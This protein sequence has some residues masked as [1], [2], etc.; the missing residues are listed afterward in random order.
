MGID[1]KG[2]VYY[3]IPIASEEDLTGQQFGL[4]TVLKR[5][6][7]EK[8]HKKHWLCLCACGNVNCVTTGNLIH[9][10]TNSCGCN[11]GK[12][13]AE[14][15]R[16][17][18]V[19]MKFGR[20]T[21]VSAVYIDGFGTMWNCDCDCGGH[22][23]VSGANLRSGITESCGCLHR[24]MM[25]SKW[26]K[27]L[28]GQKFGKL[29]ALYPSNKTSGERKRRM[30]HCICDCGNET[31]VVTDCL[32]SGSILSCGCV[33][34]S[35]GEQQIDKML[36]ENNIDFL[37]Q[38]TFSDLFG[39]DGGLLRYDFAILNSENCIE[40]LIEFDGPQHDKPADFF[41]GQ[42]AY[43]KLV[44]HDKRKNE[45]AFIHNIPLVRIPYSQRDKITL[46]MLLGNQ[47]TIQN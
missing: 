29:T 7:V 40:R 4:L 6:M 5:V 28:T 30:W 36:R 44:E 12:A 46:D 17:D 2:R 19:G 26:S 15:Q 39:V 35:Y 10:K 11:A 27:D 23:L 3:D 14:K 16:I 37:P 34:T 20:L 41:G 43:D 22:T 31:D 38:K 8:T 45:Y 32:T 24:E 21:V 1:C 9:G 13:C 25:T 47:F 42:A 33:V 18:L